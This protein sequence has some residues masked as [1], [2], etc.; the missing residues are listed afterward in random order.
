MV[1][2]LIKFYLKFICLTSKIELDVSDTTSVFL[3]SDNPCLI[4]VWHGKMLMLPEICSNLSTFQVLTSRHRDGGYIANFLGLYGHTVIKG[5]S[6]SGGFYA[7]RKIIKQL[8]I[9]QKIVIAPDGPKGPKYRVNSVVEKLAIK[10]NIPVIYASYA[11]SKVKIL[12][13]WDNFNVPLPFGKIVVR[14]SETT[15]LGK[16][17]GVNLE[18]LMLEQ[19]QEVEEDCL[20]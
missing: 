1:L 18:Q 19:M 9:G 14:F 17:Q 6:S 3:R 16:M 11:A 4:T 2:V 15:D 13:T 20:K 10:L 12:Q 5:S 8:R 7:L